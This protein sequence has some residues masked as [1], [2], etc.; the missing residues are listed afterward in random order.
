M[1]RGA[2]LVFDE[3]GQADWP[4]ETLAVLE[5]VG[6]RNLR[7]ERFPFTSQPSFAVLE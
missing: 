1:P 6:L 5:T 3:L 2:V 7:I 4:G